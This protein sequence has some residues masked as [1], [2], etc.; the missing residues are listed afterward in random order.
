MFPKALAHR[1]TVCPARR[2]LGLGH[3]G[4]AGLLCHVKAL[5]GVQP[6][7]VAWPSLPW[8]PALS[9]GERP[10]G[11]SPESGSLGCKHSFWKVD[12][13]GKSRKKILIRGCYFPAV[14]HPHW[15]AQVRN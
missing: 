8:P 9:A 10:F 6:S 3:T 2:G 15:T 4:W 7:C 5:A 11:I 13:G 1:E 14:L 12:S